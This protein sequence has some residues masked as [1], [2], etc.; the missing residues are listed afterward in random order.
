MRARHRDVWRMAAKVAAVIRGRMLAPAKGE[1]GNEKSPQRLGTGDLWCYVGHSHHL[2]AARLQG[3]NKQH[4]MAG[5][6]DQLRSFHLL[7][8]GCHRLESA[9]CFVQCAV[10]D[11]PLCCDVM[12]LSRVVSLRDL[13]RHTARDTATL[14]PPR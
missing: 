5:P 12:L 8:P 6:W 11:V 14:D 13:S 9:D 7:T 2:P 4:L 3:A 10:C 1:G